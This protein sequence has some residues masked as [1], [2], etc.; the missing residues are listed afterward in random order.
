MHPSFPVVLG[1]MRQSDPWRA[2]SKAAVVRVHQQRNLTLPG[3]DY[4]TDLDV[5][6]EAS[7]PTPN[8]NPKPNPDPNPNPNPNPTPTPSPTPNP[9]PRCTWSRWRCVSTRL[10]YVTCSTSQA[11]PTPAPSPNLS[12]LP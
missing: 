1:P 6:T 3:L 9:A 11:A 7:N 10:C 5:H 4:F 12:P 2:A 8:P